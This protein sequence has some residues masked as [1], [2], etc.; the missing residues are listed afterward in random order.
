MAITEI[1]IERLATQTRAAAFSGD[2][3]VG[4]FIDGPL[5]SERARLGMRLA[6]RL[7]RNAPADGGAFFELETGEEAFCRARLPAGLSEGASVRGLILAEAR[8]GKLARIGFPKDSSEDAAS[9]PLEHWRAGLPGAD[10][11]EIT[12]T[13]HPQPALGEAFERAFASLHILPGG[14]LIHLTETPALIAIDVDT[15]GRASRSGP[16]QRALDVNLEAARS[17]A[18]ALAL[19][20]LGGLT[21]LDC[22]APL[23]REAGGQVKAAFL[24]R[25][26]AITNRKAAALAP[27]PFGLMEISLAWA[28]TPLSHL[29]EDKPGQFS[30]LGMVLE[31]LRLVEGEARANAGDRLVLHLP[32][33]AL[34]LALKNAADLTS[35]LDATYGARLR[36]D[37]DP[38]DSIQVR[39]A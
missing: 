28:A 33:P 37:P 34:D 23:S 19:S 30:A 17:A 22:I 6:A 24:D 7:I 2:V 16:S 8:R 29:F 1:F 32:A 13:R 3:P 9:P 4:V 25:V 11:A 31:G 18:D 35:R 26:R 5:V 39:P 15:S 10:T 12:E 38:S 36:L 14:G 21:V 27:S 20:G